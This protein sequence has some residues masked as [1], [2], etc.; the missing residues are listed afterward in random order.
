MEQRWKDT[1]AAHG[2][3]G[4]T[5]RQY[6]KDKNITPSMF[7]YWKK[8]LAN[9]SRISPGFVAVNVNAKHQDAIFVIGYANGVKLHLPGKVSPSLLRELIYV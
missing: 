5:A 2:A 1:M 4:L 3:S 6:C 7:Y 8:K 9:S